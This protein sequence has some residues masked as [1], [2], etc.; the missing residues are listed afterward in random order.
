MSSFSI[1]R[2]RTDYW[3]QVLPLLPPRLAPGA[4]V[5]CES[6]ARPELPAGWEAWKQSRAGQVTISTA[7][8]DRT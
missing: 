3:P 1:R 8:T 7:E 6:A 5:Y 2:F 4:V